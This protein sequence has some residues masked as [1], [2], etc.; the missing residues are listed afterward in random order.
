[1]NK[2]RM[3]VRFFLWLTTG[4][5]LLLLSGCISKIFPPK[6]TTASLEIETSAD[7]NPN[8]MGRPSPLVLWIYQLK[9]PFCFEKADFMT[10]YEK[11]ESF[12][13]TDL[14]KKQEIILKVN[15][16]QTVPIEVTDEINALGLMALFRDYEQSHWK[17]TATIIPHKDNLI[18]VTIQ[19]TT[20]TVN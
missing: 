4:L 6:P 14:I 13:S 17:A 19:G 3:H 7:I 20:L 8:P 1:M 5:V 2:D 18:N 12:L 11:S 9:S 10:L 16:K 15:E